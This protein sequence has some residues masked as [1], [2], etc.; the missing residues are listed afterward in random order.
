MSRYVTLAKLKQLADAAR[1]EAKDYAR[2]R[3]I[4]ARAD[5]QMYVDAGVD[6]AKAHAGTKATDAEAAAVAYAD[7]V[8]A[9]F[10]GLDVLIP[11]T[12]ETVTAVKRLT[13]LAPAAGLAALTIA[14]PAGVHN[15]RRRIASTRAITNLT[16]SPAAGET[17]VGQA[18]GS[19][20]AGGFFELCF[21][22]GATKTWVRIG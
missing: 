16:Y 22:N 4:S 15:Q 6:E 11:A 21:I 12:G 7:D 18:P 13:V 14:L 9:Q 3:L 5:L 2:S 8:A 17:V 10:L 1:E 19:L 20:A